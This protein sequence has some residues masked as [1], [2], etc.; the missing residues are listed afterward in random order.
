MEANMLRF[1]IALKLWS[2]R[3]LMRAHGGDITDEFL[4]YCYVPL[5]YGLPF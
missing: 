5:A 1:F 3:A 2:G 4:F